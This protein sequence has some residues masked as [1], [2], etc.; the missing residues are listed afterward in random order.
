MRWEGARR[1]SSHTRLMR[2]KDVATK[3]CERRK[4]SN[5]GSPQINA[6]DE[7]GC[8]AGATE[9]RPGPLPCWRR[10]FLQF[11]AVVPTEVAAGSEIGPPLVVFPNLVVM[12]SAWLPTQ[13]ALFENVTL[14]VA[15]QF[16]EAGLLG[17]VVAIGENDQY[18][19]LHFAAE[20]GQEVC[21][22]PEFSSSG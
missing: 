13:R 18:L 6:D 22:P 1:T 4:R 12:R 2:D 15:I 8:A 14:S 21:L 20:C 16:Q 10:G 9:S 5:H 11:V 3:E 17:A 19:A 7:S